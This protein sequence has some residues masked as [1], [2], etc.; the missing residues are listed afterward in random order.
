MIGFSENARRLR[1]L[2][3]TLTGMKQVEGIVLN[4]VTMGMTYLT[5]VVL[6]TNNILAKLVTQFGMRHGVAVAANAKRT[7]V[8]NLMP[9]MFGD[10]SF[11]DVFLEKKDCRSVGRWILIPSV[12]GQRLHDLFHSLPPVLLSSC[13][14]RVLS[15]VWAAFASGRIPIVYDWGLLFD[16]KIKI[17]SIFQ[18]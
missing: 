18:I 4:S 3:V 8:T 1:Q 6:G 10:P 7:I 13:S 9:D 15:S 11:D 2:P 16:V 5:L 14:C 12:G 17:P